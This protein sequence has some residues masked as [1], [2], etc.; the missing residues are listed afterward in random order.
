MITQNKGKDL[1]KVPKSKLS[2]GPYILSKK[3][4]GHYVQIK[5]DGQ[6]KVEMWTS[7][8][9]PF[10]IADLAHDIIRGPLTEFHIECE[11]NYDCE[12]YLGDRGKSAILTTYRTNYMKGDVTLGSSKDIFR[13]LDLLHLPEHCFKDRLTELGDLFGNW[14]KW[15]SVPN[16]IECPSLEAALLTSKRWAK[17]GYEGGMLKDPL[18]F[19]EMDDRKQIRL[20]SIIKIKPRLTADLLC[21]GWK[22]GTGKY[23]GVLGSLELR[24]SVGRTVWAGSG[25]SDFDRTSMGG[26]YYKG[27]VIEVEY[28]RIDET[29]IQPIIK[30]VRLD[31]EASD[32]D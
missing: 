15:F 23:E 21:I 17:E 9:K 1:H 30:G 29:Y 8:G 19:Y 11:Y 12:G 14:N 20:N 16:F 4:D 27:K 13:V 3:F 22:I 24:D 28:E 18:H 31:K 5:Y 2:D 32:I 25:L 6:S 26:D 7:G 10:Y